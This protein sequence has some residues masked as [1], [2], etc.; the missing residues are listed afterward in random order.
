MLKTIAKK[1]LVYA[2]IALL[3]AIG[4]QILVWRI[5]NH[6]AFVP[7]YIIL[8]EITMVVLLGFTANFRTVNS[9][10]LHHTSALLLIGL[11]SAANLSSLVFI[12]N[13]LIFGHSM[14]SGFDL[15]SSAIVIFITNIIVFALWYW[16]I[17]SPGLTGTNWSKH[18][19]DFQFTQQN[20]VQEFP[21]W[22][23]EFI[24]YLFLSIIN[25]FNGATTGAHPITHQAKML[26]ALQAMVSIF[27]L[28]LVIARSV[29][30]LG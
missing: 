4:L 25:A 23:P 29:S 26:M 12:L 8:I 30:I 27:T 18:D 13:S 28:A 3:L 6:L 21:S 11:I 10:K 9:K 2:Q 15:L 1:E 14:V 17:D 7:E 24:D 20:M 16:E 5:N 22:K 19:K